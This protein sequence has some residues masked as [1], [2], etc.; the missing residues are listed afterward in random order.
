MILE[1]VEQSYRAAADRRSIQPYT[2]T[3]AP[4]KPRSPSQTTEGVRPEIMKSYCK[5]ANFNISSLT[6][7]PIL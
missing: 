2:R 3:I 5:E 4:T 1:G 7:E 6:P